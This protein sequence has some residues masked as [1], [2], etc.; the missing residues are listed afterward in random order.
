VQSTTI[1]VPEANPRHVRPDPVVAW[2]GLPAQLEAAQTDTVHAERASVVLHVIL[3]EVA[4]PP[5]RYAVLHTS[6]VAEAMIAD[7]ALHVESPNVPKAKLPKRLV[8]GVPTKSAECISWSDT[9]VE[10]TERLLMG[11]TTMTDPP[12][13]L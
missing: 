11:H 10:V 7:P 1:E 4:A 6:Y 2:A 5:K 12:A 3:Y 8:A 9:S 13:T